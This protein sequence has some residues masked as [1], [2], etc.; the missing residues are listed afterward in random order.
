MDRRGEKGSIERGRQ[1]CKEGHR[2]RERMAGERGQE[3]ER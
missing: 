1:E 2:E 3:R